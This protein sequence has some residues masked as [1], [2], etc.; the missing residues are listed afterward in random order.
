V[1]DFNRWSS[2]TS[3]SGIGLQLR[4]DASVHGAEEVGSRIHGFAHGQDAVVL[5]NDCFLVTERFC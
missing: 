5:E 2:T 4:F 3:S 1:I